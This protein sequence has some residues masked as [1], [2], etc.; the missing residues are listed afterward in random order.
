[1]S[2]SYT[3]GLKV[4]TKTKIIKQ[5]QLPLKGVVHLEKGMK[6]YPDTIVASTE[7]PGNVHMVN[8]SNALNVEPDSVEDYLKIKID[9][10]VEK[11]QV[12]AETDGFFGYFKGQAFSPVEGTLANISDVTGQA[13]IS[14]KPQPIE[15]DAYTEGTVLRTI[16]D[17]GV[18][19]ESEGAII[20]G[21]LGIG[22][23]KRGELFILADRPSAIVTSEQLNDKH[24]NLILVC[25]AYIDFDFFQKAIKIG[26]A[27][28]VCGG[29]D[30]QDLSRIL[31]FQLGVAITGS[32]NIPI[33]LIITE[34]FGEIAM[35]K[36]SFELLKSFERY[37]VSING[38]TQIRAG[39]IRPE[40]IIVHDDNSMK[41]NI[42][43]EDDLVISNGSVVRIIRPPYF[44]KV[45]TVVSLPA[46]LTELESETK[47]RVAEIEFDDGNKDIFPRANL[48]LIIG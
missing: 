28:I 7:I 40:V 20:Q 23:E 43:N 13:L 10:T 15:I 32:E 47:V 6:V 16:P 17:E 33:S 24:R 22:G 35:A 19:I 27:G 25:G 9:D 41:T 29:F 21:I 48:E 18:E 44:G 34:G 3:P 42:I 4:L 8:I 46:Q 31:G 2:K 30:Y 39:V 14:E 26:V 38:S 36:R 45:G 12:I 11:G 37:H 1:M 5:R